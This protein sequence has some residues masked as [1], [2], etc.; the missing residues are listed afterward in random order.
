M[1]KPA[2][3]TSHDVVAAARRA[4]GTR[5]VGHAGTLDPFATGLLI[6]V[7]GPATRMARLVERYP[8]CYR[9]EAVIGVTTDT[10]D[11]E[12]E[13]TGGVTP[14]TWPD[15]RALEAVLEQFRG[16]RPQR[17]PAFSARRVDGRRAYQLARSGQPVEL[18]ETAVTVY[19][20][21]ATDWSPPIL[22]F[23]AD[24]SAGTYIRALGR[25]IGERLGLGGHLRSLRRTAIGPHRVEQAT[26][27]A[28]LGPELVPLPPA[29]LVPD[30]P[31]L[32]LTAEERRDV[33][34]GRSVFREPAVGEVGLMWE[35]RLVAVGEGQG[36]RWHPRLVLEPL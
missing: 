33:G 14:E 2:G 13:V 28:A 15:R 10:D 12:G 30:L 5:A 18:P 32:Q 3:P 34:H 9:A 36:D 24:V 6:L 20:L 23:E 25:D 26:P 29:S 8:K 11:A 27:L 4:L 35:G 16:A 17:P 21:E 7:I 19:R 1:D 22:T 31:R